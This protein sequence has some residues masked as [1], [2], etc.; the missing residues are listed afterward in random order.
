MW[1]VDGDDEVRRSRL[2]A[3]HVAFGKTPEAA[4]AWVS[5]VDEPNAAMVRAGRG[6]PT[7]SSWWPTTA[8]GSPTEGA[9]P[10]RFSGAQGL[11]ELAVVRDEAVHVVLGVGERDQPLLVE[12][13]RGEDLAVDAPE[14]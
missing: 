9:R 1:F 14:P 3:R 7:A 5:A 13:G 11:R 4:A 6:P 8:G 10:A 12:P 2:V